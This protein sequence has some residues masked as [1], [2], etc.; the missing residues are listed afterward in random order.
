MGDRRLALTRGSSLIFRLS[1]E[2]LPDLMVLAGK[3]LRVADEFVRLGVPQV[4]PLRVASGLWS[5]LVTI[6][7]FLDP[8]SFLQA[9]QRQL[10]EMGIQGTASLLSTA[11]ATSFEGG[12][13]SRSSFIRRTLRIRDKEIVGFSV[14]VGGLSPE[15]S[16]RLQECGLG[17]RQRMGCG[18]FVPKPEPTKLSSRS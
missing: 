13:G 9:A 12:T 6:K 11:E 8:D 3:R 15:G 1:H 4:M 16:I 7:G 10:V 2:R 18:V 17:G 5:R 14:N